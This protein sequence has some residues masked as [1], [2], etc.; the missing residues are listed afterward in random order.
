MYVLKQQIHALAAEPTWNMVLTCQV[1][2]CLL[3]QPF[4]LGTVF[5]TELPDQTLVPRKQSVSR[6]T[7]QKIGGFL[8]SEEDPFDEDPTM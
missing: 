8:G 3:V 4:H 6:L 2:R 1:R 7:R 5:R